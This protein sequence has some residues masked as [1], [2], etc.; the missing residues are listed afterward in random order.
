MNK[1]ARE[2]GAAFIMEQEEA[3]LP[4]APVKPKLR[5]VTQL[6]RDYGTYEVSVDGVVLGKV[7]KQWHFMNDDE[8]FRTGSDVSYRTRKD[9]VLALML[10]GGT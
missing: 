5:R 7:W 8:W 1:A 3:P 9:A 4:P 2:A 10:D 6:G